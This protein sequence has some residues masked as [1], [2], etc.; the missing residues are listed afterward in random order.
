MLLAVHAR[1]GDDTAARIIG[2]YAFAIW[3][4]T[5]RCALLAVDPGGMRTLSL[6]V[7]G[8]ELFI[9]SEAR[10]L[11]AQG[12]IDRVLDERRVGEWLALLGRDLED[13]S[14]FA[15]IR[16]VPPGGRAIWAGGALAVD[17]WWR[18][19][20]LPML[21]LPR[22]ADYAEAV[23][24]A[25]DTAV[26][27]RLGDDARVG[28]HL[29][30]GL[31]SSIVTA[32]AARRLGAQGRGLTAFTAVPAHAADAVPGRFGDE[33]PHAAAVAALHP[34]ITHVAASNDDMPVIDMLDLREPAQDVPLMNVSNRV[35]ANAIDRQARDRGVTIMLIAGG[36]NMTFTY[37][38]GLLVPQLM[39]RGSVARAVRET[40]AMRRT[41]GRRW[42][43]AAGLLAESALP[44][45]WGQ[46]LR[47]RVRH[48]GETPVEYSTIRSAF[49]DQH[50]IARRRKARGGDMRNL[51]P[52]DSRALRLAVL[53]GNGVQGEFVNATRRLYGIDTRDP[54]TD[55]RLVE[56]CLSIPEEQFQ[57]AGMPRAI[58]RTLGRDLVPPVVR[59][60]QRR[61]LQAIDWAHGVEAALPRLKADVASL[62]AGRNVPDWIDL[63]R[64]EH[65]IDHWPGVARADRAEW[66][67]VTRGLAAGRFVRRIE[68]SNR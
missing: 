13:D 20:S 33:W 40:L 57:H 61:G 15:G 10:G 46:E 6:H 27:C 24:D 51:H 26:A 28:S 54:T 3:D 5:A 4:G 68:G 47:R 65:A 21:H 32:V 64:I 53:Q 50:D 63:D 19:D 49:A 14:F 52:L 41:L 11:F 45:R 36:G 17:L 35:W 55:R 31:D 30:G 48:R 8:H 29:S 23:H 59:D 1:C 34:N 42:L 43:W 9:A 37:D 44:R 66:T 22:H 56:L 38:G 2:D 62:R 58:A 39:R 16:R 18:P 7:R 25:L 60:E 67:A 12:S